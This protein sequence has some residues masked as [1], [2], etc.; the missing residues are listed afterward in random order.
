ML[1]FVCDEN[2]MVSMQNI[3]IKQD[4]R[5]I[6]KTEIQILATFKSLVIIK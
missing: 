5:S 3:H 2:E 4:K 1:C 6:L